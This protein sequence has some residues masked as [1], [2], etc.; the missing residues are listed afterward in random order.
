[1]K[2]CAKISI[3]RALIGCLHAYLYQNVFFS[4]KD[5]EPY[6]S[7][8]SLSLHNI[9][10]PIHPDPFFSLV[11]LNCYSLPLGTAPS[12][13]FLPRWGSLHCLFYWAHF[14]PSFPP[15]KLPHNL[16]RNPLPSLDRSEQPRTQK[17]SQ[18]N[19]A[20]TRPSD[21]DIIWQ[22]TLNGGRP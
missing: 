6:G 11:P 12:R 21:R 5:T 17:Y 9:L 13:F 10:L 16:D 3:A 8:S 18:I 19:Q 22:G 4:P 7:T 14:P 15:T 20:I 1:M 2:R